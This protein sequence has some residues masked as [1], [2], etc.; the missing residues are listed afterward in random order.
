MFLCMEK[1]NVWTGEPRFRTRLCSA[2]RVVMYFPLLTLQKTAR[3]ALGVSRLAYVYAR[4]R[5][6]THFTQLSLRG[7]ME[8]TLSS[9]EQ[10]Q[11]THVVLRSRT[12]VHRQTV[13][14]D[15]VLDRGK[16]GEK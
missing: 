2:V 1:R 11:H 13:R 9:G 14:L 5:E 7:P 3:D 15:R 6:P 4:H 12:P 8:K 10:Q 16:E